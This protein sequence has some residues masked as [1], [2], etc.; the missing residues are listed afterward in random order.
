MWKAILKLE[1]LDTEYYLKTG[2][3]IP[4]STM[5]DLL[6]G[7]IGFDVRE[8]LKNQKQTLGDWEKMNYSRLRSIIQNRKDEKEY[9]AKP[10][11]RNAME[12]D[13]LRKTEQDADEEDGQEE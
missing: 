12:I 8:Y 13:A 7:G 2:E 4:D 10:G 11:G 9:Y 3:H 1:Q 6:Q 5:T